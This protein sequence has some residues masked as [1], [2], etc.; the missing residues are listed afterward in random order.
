MHIF[1]KFC[2]WRVNMKGRFSMNNAEFSTPVKRLFSKN[3]SMTLGISLAVLSVL[4]LLKSI[5]AA[6]YAQRDNL[7]ASLYYIFGPGSVSV[8]NIIM[9]VITSVTIFAI[10]MGILTARFT[11]S[12][13]S[14]SFGILKGSLIASIVVTILLVVCS[15]ASVTVMN[16]SSVEADSSVYY[17]GRYVNSDAEVLFWMTIVLG[18]LLIFSEISLVRFTGSLSANAEGNTFNKNGIIISAF[19]SVS[20]AVFSV[21]A[22]GVCLY[23][24]VTP[25]SEYVDSV[26]RDSA[27]AGLQTS[28][29]LLDTSNVVIFAALVVVF[30]AIAVMVSSYSADIDRILRMERA[31][32][33]NEAHSVLDPVAYPDYTTPNNYNYYQSQNFAPYYDASRAYYDVNKNIYTGEVPPV[34]QAPVNPFTPAASK[35]QYPTAAQPAAQQTYQNQNVSATN[36]TA[37][38]PAPAQNGTNK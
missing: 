26:Y 36:D 24:L 6:V 38:V 21:I 25:S 22:F 34:P 11:A 2:I 7:Y 31:N 19:S 4:V 37:E 20:S 27:A 8:V 18:A 33:Y 3:S 10:A 1:I 29:L 23:N 28:K 17:L 35:T 16:Y 9:G 5:C 13:S 30:I 15:F 14:G 12:R 32:A